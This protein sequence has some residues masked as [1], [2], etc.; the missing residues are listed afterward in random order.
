MAYITLPVRSDIPA[1]QFQIELEGTTY[2]FDF[3]WNERADCWTMDISN[4]DEVL[5]IAGIKLTCG[6][7]LLEK[8]I[9]DGLPLGDF[10]L[11]DTTGKNLDPSA[12]ELGNRVLLMYRESTTVDE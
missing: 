1:Y 11:L 10:L 8:F 12:N 4:S 5:L 7:S 3:E 6:F 2:F 9:I